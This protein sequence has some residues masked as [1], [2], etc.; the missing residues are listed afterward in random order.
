[1][2]LYN[3]TNHVAPE[4]ESQ[5]L[6]WLNKTHLPEMMAN[7]VFTSALV[8]RVYDGFEA[9]EKVYAIQYSAN[10]HDD[11]DRFLKE[12]KQKLKLQSLKLFGKNVLQFSTQ[13]E[14]LSQHS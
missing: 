11:L 12:N 6:E 5:W 4:I 2:I 10:N 9:A 8:L 1:M 3:V 7:G 14:V 13:L